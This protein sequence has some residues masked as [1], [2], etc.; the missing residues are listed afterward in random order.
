MTARRGVTLI[1]LLVVL[2]LLG[3]MAGVVGLALRSAHSVTQVDIVA[4]EAARARDSAVRSGRAVSLM[5]ARDSQFFAAT[6]LPDG[7]VVADKKLA[8]DPLSGATDAAP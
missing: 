5:I 4:I 1:E 6:A 8:I 7:R 2:V 3:M